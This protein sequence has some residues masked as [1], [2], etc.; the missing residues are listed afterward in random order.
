MYSDPF[1][2]FYILLYCS[3]MLRSFQ[4][5][6]SPHQS[7]LNT[8]WW[9]SE[10]WIFEKVL[11]RKNWNI[12]LTKVC[13]P[14]TQYLA[15]AQPWVFLGMTQQA[16]HTWDWGIFCHY[17]L[18][19]LSSSV[20]LDG[21]LR[22]PAAQVSPEMF[23]WVRVRALAEPLKDIHRK[24]SPSHPCV[25]VAG[26][27]GSLSCWKVNHRP[28]LRSWVLWAWLSLNISLYLAPFS[29]P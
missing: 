25:V 13:K 7:T 16:L 17:S 29:F 19:I 9:Q 24:S 3:L 11:E 5:I 1:I 20:R 12:T 6:F 18:Q 15:E 28:R 14:F 2:F 27:L 22:W 8:P 23:H 10:N 21:D 26:C 4:F